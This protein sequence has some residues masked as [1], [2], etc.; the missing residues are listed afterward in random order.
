[1]YR[2]GHLASMMQHRA[3]LHVNKKSSTM[4]ELGQYP[5]E[6]TTLGIFWCGVI[7]QTGSLLAGRVADTTLARTTHKVVCRYR[8]DIVPEMWLIIDGDRYDILYVMDPYLNK[9]RLEIFTE[10]VI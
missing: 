7:P 1:M 8:S 2:K 5:I 9:E 4:N 3:E 10:V 6:D